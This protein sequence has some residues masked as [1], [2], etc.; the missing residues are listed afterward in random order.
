[1]RLFTRI[2]PL[3]QLA[4][5][6]INLALERRLEVVDASGPEGLRLWKRA[7]LVAGHDAEVV[8]AAAEGEPQVAVFGA[9]GGDGFAR[10]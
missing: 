8:A 9:A 4:H 1:M 2:A 10:G 6:R 3:I 5:E 7:Q